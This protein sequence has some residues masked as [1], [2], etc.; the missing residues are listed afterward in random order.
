MLSLIETDEPRHQLNL[1]GTQPKDVVSNSIVAQNL[2]SDEGKILDILGSQPIHI[3]D[4]AASIGLRSS[5][6]S[7][8]I[9]ALE[10]AG[11]AADLGGKNFVK[12]G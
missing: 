6:T 1:P 10:I 9:L 2:S 3:D 8:A 11:L 4:I 5:E 7:A 12:V